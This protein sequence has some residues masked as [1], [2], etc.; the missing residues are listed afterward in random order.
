MAAPQVRLAC[1]PD[2]ETY[3]TVREPAPCEYGLLLLLPAMCAHSEYK[4]T[5]LLQP[6]S[7]VPLLLAQRLALLRCFGCH[8]LKAMSLTSYHQEHGAD[9]I[10]QSVW[11]LNPGIHCS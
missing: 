10:L 5:W 2:Q 3:L 11:T 4:P 7:Q 1:S 6:Q 9:L 8:L